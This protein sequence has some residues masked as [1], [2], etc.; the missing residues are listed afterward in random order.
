MFR[1][2]DYVMVRVSDM[3]RSVRFY[4]DTLG[5]ALRFQTPD[6]SEFDTGGT[7]LA[8]HNGAKEH[9]AGRQ[10]DGEPQA[11]SC[12]IGFQLEDLDATVK[13]LEAKGV[14]FLMPPTERVT[15][16]IRLAIAADPDGLAISFAQVLP[17]K[18]G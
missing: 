16:G 17:V 4:R 9:P 2:P 12:S 3:E 18:A 15:E 6:W 14:R 7:T 5:L 10:S 11:G 1:K 8:L 13:L